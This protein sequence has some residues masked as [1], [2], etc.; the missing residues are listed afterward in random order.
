VVDADARRRL[1]TERAT[2]TDATSSGGNATLLSLE[3]VG[4]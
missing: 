3:D 4:F 1:R 2:S